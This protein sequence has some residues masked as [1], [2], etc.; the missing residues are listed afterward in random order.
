MRSRGGLFSVE[1][2]RTVLE[3]R[4]SRTESDWRFTS[5]LWT[6]VV[7]E[8]RLVTV[9]TPVSDTVRKAETSI[10]DMVDVDSTCLLPAAIVDKVLLIVFFWLDDIDLL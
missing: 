9:D 6:E 2:K 7:E 1:V 4:S 3:D 5:F 10:A 8:I